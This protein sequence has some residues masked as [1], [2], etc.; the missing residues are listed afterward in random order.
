MQHLVSEHPVHTSDRAS[1]WNTYGSERSC[2][3]LNDGPISIL[4]NPLASI[5]LA[6]EFL[7]ETGVFWVWVRQNL[8]KLGCIDPYFPSD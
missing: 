7:E 1:R 8:C 4:G 3:C 5:E 6:V 2:S